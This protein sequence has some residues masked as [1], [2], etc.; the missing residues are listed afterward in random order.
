[1]HIYW[2]KVKFH[3]ILTR[4][5]PNL[6]KSRLSLFMFQ[7]L[8]GYIALYLFTLWTVFEEMERADA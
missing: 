6:L 5:V 4:L 7:H 1:M 3:H 2:A 8:E